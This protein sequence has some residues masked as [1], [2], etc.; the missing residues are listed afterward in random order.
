M[1]E[2]TSKYSVSSLQ[3]LESSKEIDLFLSCL[4][5]EE[6]CTIIP[7][8]LNSNEIKNN[9]FFI[10]KPT[11]IDLD[12]KTRNATT[13]KDHLGKIN[14]IELVKDDPLETARIIYSSLLANN[15]KS[16]KKILIDITT[17]THE[18]L[19]ILIRIIT[20]MASSNQSIYLAYNPAKEYA[21]TISNDKDKWLSKGVKEIRTVLGYPGV[22]EPR[23]EF[24]LIILAGMEFERTGKLIESFEPSLLSLGFPTEKGSPA[25]S[26]FKKNLDEYQKILSVYHSDMIKLFEFSAYDPIKSKEMIFDHYKKYLDY[27]TVIAPMNNK[28]STVAVG[29][30]SIQETKIQLCYPLPN[31]HNMDY[32]KSGSDIYIHRLL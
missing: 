31:I 24:H 10:N 1:K 5:F 27:N 21:P 18:S 7:L 13:I 30:L 8:A 16:R 6:R 4:S 15:F 28:L 25:F 22:F 23:K 12:L 9:L 17:F 29:L 11:S 2:Q 14:T 3:S 32:S 20:H 26:A 19:L